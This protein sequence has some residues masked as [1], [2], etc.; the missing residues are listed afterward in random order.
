MSSCC[1]WR[2]KVHFSW[3]NSGG[4]G[5]LFTSEGHVDAQ[6]A[7][8][9]QS[10]NEPIEWSV[11]TP[12]RSLNGRNVQVKRIRPNFLSQDGVPAWE[13]NA[14]Y[15]YNL[16]E[17]ASVAE[18]APGG[19]GSWDVGTWDSSVWQS[20]LGTADYRSKGSTGVGRDFAI[21]LR[22]T[23]NGRTVLVG[24]D[25]FFQVGGAL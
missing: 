4:L 21:A 20:E 10:L 6:G 18:G 15:N 16:T 1:V 8:S 25:V 13:A 22:G 2:K 24:M 14:R 7:G 17:L 11:I 23:A 5:A 3:V 9:F 12:F 19:S